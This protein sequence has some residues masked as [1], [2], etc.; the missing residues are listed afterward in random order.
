MDRDKILD[1]TKKAL[2]SLLISAPRGVAIH[3]LAKDY[4][5]VMGKEL[6]YRELGYRSLDDFISSIPDT[7]RIGNGPGG[8]TCYAVANAETQQIARFVALSKK[9]ALKKS[10]RPPSIIGK[11]TKVS[12]FSKRNNFGPA[13][14]RPKKFGGRGGGGAWSNSA[15]RQYL[16]AGYKGGGGGGWGG[17]SKFGKPFHTKQP[18]G[19]SLASTKSHMCVY[20]CMCTCISMSTV[21]LWLVIFVGAKFREKSKKAFRINFRNCHTSC[22]IVSTYE[23]LCVCKYW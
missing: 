7:I 15:S 18:S 10:M 23:P 14:S 9:P 1:K 8:L 20:Q 4:N 2:R 19:K 6:P 11:P 16:P 5:M 17:G 21:T 22:V 13:Y 3:L 12:G